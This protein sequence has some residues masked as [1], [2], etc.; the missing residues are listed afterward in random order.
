MY[1]GQ[2]W[3]DLD[4]AETKE[5]LSIEFTNDLEPSETITSATWTLTVLKTL[6]G[7]TADPSPTSRLI[8]GATPSTEID[9]V[10]GATRTFVNQAL[11]GCI[12]GNRYIGEA[13]A[14]TSTGRTPAR[15]SRFWCRVP[16]RTP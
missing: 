1:V 10:S 5:V 16:S 4:P 3:D 11:G 12:D 9:P 2:D 7:A 13:V 15:F 14:T 8:G 6:T